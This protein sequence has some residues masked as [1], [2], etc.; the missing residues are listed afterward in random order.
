MLC[1][2]W[3]V[4]LFDPLQVLLH[5]VVGQARLLLHLRLRRA[6]GLELLELILVL[7]E[8]RRA[9]DLLAFGALPPFDLKY[10][11]INSGS[12][13]KWRW[14]LRSSYDLVSHAL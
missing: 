7:L 13:T 12:S 8:L 6:I 2:E 4:A 5:R 10:G 3:L 11:S 9:A 14:T 1:P